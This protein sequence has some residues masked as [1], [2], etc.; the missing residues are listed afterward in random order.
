MSWML[1]FYLLSY[2]DSVTNLMT[3]A[4]LLAVFLYLVGD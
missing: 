4:K 3:L 1:S 2:R